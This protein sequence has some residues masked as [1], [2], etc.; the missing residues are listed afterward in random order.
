MKSLMSS[1]CIR[2]LSVCSKMICLSKKKC[3]FHV[4]IVSF[5]GFVV[6]PASMQMDP[7]KVIAVASWS[8]PTSQ[9]QIQMFLGFVNFYRKF[10]RD[11]SVITSPL[12]ALISPHVSFQLSPQADR[13]VFFFN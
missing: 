1:M 2:C 3:E 5:L 8:S 4:N 6:F 9:K 13:V 7:S 11:F 10:F 12:H